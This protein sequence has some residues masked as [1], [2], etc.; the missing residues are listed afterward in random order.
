MIRKKILNMK[1]DVKF[2]EDGTV[3]VTKGLLKGIKFPEEGSHNSFY[4]SNCG[5][6]MSHTSQALMFQDY[7]DTSLTFRQYVQ[8]CLK[9]NTKNIGLK[10]TLYMTGLSYTSY[11]NGINSDHQRKNSGFNKYLRSLVGVKLVFNALHNERAKR[12]ALKER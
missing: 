4:I 7:L 6:Y 11:K 1:Y 3:E 9:E 12:D 8:K 2:N 5:V 10:D